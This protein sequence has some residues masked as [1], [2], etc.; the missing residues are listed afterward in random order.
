[1]TQ[2]HGQQPTPGNGRAAID[3]E[4]AA[5]PPLVRLLAVAIVGGLAA[6]ALWS[7]PALR[8]A[9]WTFP[10]LA[11]FGIAAV[12]IGWMGWWMV[13]SRT[14]FRS[15]EDGGVIVQT[16]LWDKRVRAADV[17]SFKIVHWPWFQA[18]IAPRILLR[19]KGG[20][21][22]WVHAAD[23]GLLVAFGESVVRVGAVPSA[24]SSS[25]PEAQ[26]R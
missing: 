23:A 10:A 8:N 4:S 1:M 26:A 5:F 6:F 3:I 9:Q 11:T 13:F 24:L 2:H 16:W 7:I 14:R 19:R 21:I 18:V 15:T 20:G 25:P 17:A 22:T 12:L